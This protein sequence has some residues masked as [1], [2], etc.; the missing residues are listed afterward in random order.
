MSLVDP[1]L[2]RKSLA[3]SLKTKAQPPEDVPG[4]YVVVWHKVGREW[5]LGT[6]IWNT[7]K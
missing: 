1:E 6:D 7:N 4:K 3:F 2:P 5:K